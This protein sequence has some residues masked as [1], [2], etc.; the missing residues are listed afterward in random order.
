MAKVKV[1]IALAIDSNGKWMAVGWKHATNDEMM[2]NAIDGMD[3]GERRYFI[4]AEV[5]APEPPTVVQGT[6][7]EVKS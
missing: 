6:V 1:R 4:E 5:E 7:S 2:D 3:S